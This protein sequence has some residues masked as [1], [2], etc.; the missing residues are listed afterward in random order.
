LK[1]VK[2]GIIGLGE[3]GR[4]LLDDVIMFMDD[5]E[6]LAVCDAYEDRALAGA[7]AVR[8]GK[9]GAV[10]CTTDYRD[11]LKMEEINAIAI[12]SAWESHVPIALAAMR[13]GKA[14]AMEVGGAYSPEDCWALVRTQ[15]ET[16]AVCMML[17]NCCYGRT[18]L[19]VTNMVRKGLFGEV[20]HCAGGYHH[21]LREQIAFGAENR[22]YRLRNYL[23]RNCDNY[24]THELGP[25][26]KLLDINN[27]NRMLTLSSFA[28]KAAGMQAYLAEK[29]PED[30]A[31]NRTAFMQGDVVTTVIKC[32]RGETIVLT[33][34][35]T[36]PRTYSRGFRVRG[37]K[38]AYEDENKSFFFDGEH[39]EFDFKWQEQWGN[40]DKYREE[41]EHPLWTAYNKEGVKNGHG[42]IDYL[43]LRA[44]FE[45]VQNG[46]EPPIDVYDTAAWMSV[47]ALSEDSIAQGG[48]PLAMPDFTGG[49]WLCK[50]PPMDTRYNLR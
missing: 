37:T 2:L 32:A 3:R 47:T 15:E 10:L 20:V 46:T 40:A 25:I 39:H 38:A 50:K 31:L 21:D 35:T 42:G 26:A 29:K 34:D 14:V 11:I 28:S 49:R 22:H 45:C 8:A 9:S 33:L 23:N 41:H 30:T 24:P 18:E 13:A 17:E 7:E 36:L 43:V 4:N 19:M 1:T 27:G 48:A 12:L 16:G 5:V 6:I 44:F